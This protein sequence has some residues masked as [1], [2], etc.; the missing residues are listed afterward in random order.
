MEH[1]Y[2][3]K[4]VYQH[5]QI[6]NFVSVKNYIF[7]RKDEKK[8]LLLRFS[9]DFDYAVNSMT[10][11]L[12]Q[13][14]AVGKVLARTKITHKNLTFRSGSMFVPEEPI[15]VDEYCSDFKIV[16][17]EVISGFYRYEVH[18]DM[19]T[20]H[21][22]KIPEPIVDISEF[23]KKEQRKFRDISV[24]EYCVNQKKFQERGS[25]AFVASILTIVMLGL[26][27]LNLYWIYISSRKP[28]F[29][30]NLPYIGDLFL[31]VN[32]VFS[33]VSQ[34]L[35]FLSEGT[36]CLVLIVFILLF[37]LIF[38][39]CYARKSKKQEKDFTQ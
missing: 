38:T 6:G 17:T 8:H 32:K 15:C 25:A 14:D 11:M 35:N 4:G 1:Q 30:G 22:I 37:C 18:P 24:E 5:P 34:H 2:I 26:N 36:G 20:V 7:I 28:G 29:M 23:E 16:F 9:N 39:V 10:Y 19:I 31:Y 13:T 12:V 27:I 3:S 33:T 21:Y